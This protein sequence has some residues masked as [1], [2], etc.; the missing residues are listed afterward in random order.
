MGMNGSTA[1]TEQDHGGIP[2][3][4]GQDGRTGIREE[5]WIR[6]GIQ[7]GIRGN[8]RVGLGLGSGVGSFVMDGAGLGQE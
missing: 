3:G 1:G 5:F 2:G 6:A 7:S 8:C 4:S